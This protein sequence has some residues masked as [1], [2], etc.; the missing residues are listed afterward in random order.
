M[1]TKKYKWHKVAETAADLQWTAGNV[2]EV[3]VEGKKLC[4]VRFNEEWYGIAHTCPHA[5]AP[6]T[7][8]Y[9]AGGCNIVCPVHNLKFNLKNGRDVNG[10]GYKLKTYPVEVRGD[11]V[12]LGVE[13][14]VGF[15]KKWF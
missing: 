15:F 5:G 4:V 12:Y 14:E 11:G 1:G 9:V 10:E 7:D 8:G 6:M 2:S 3:E 13:D